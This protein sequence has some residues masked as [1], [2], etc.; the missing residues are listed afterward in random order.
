MSS[1]IFLESLHSFIQGQ[2]PGTGDV[3]DTRAKRLREI[4]QHATAHVPLYR[5]LY[6]A[7]KIDIDGIVT[8]NDLWRLPTVEKADYLRCGAEQYVDERLSKSLGDLHK[9]TTSGS[10]GSAL[11]LYSTQEE[12]DRQF[13]ALWAAW[14]S[15]G[16]T[17]DDRLFLM[18]A[19][20]LERE[21]P[22]FYGMFVPYSTPVDQAARLFEQ[23]QPT[24][25][26]G[27]VESIAMLAKE[28][29]ERDVR[30]RA[31]VRAI[32]HFGVTYSAQMRAMIGRAFDAWTVDLYGCFEAGWLGYECEQHNGFHIPE[33]RVIVQIAHTGKPNE[34]AAPG[35]IGEVIIT[36]LLRSTM[37]FIRYRLH[38]AAAI[39]PTPCPCG[40]TSARI[41]N[42]EGRWAEFLVGRDSRLFSPAAISVELFLDH[43]TVIDH[44]I[45]QDAR[46]HLRVSLVLAD[47]LSDAERVRITSIL[48]RILGDV[49]ID[50]E[51]V[52]EIPVMP[53]GKRMRVLRTFELSSV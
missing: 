14:I 1:T 42:L 37:P 38:D 52:P 19:W 45:V 28:L 17:P 21:L 18:S 6:R 50:I 48:R 11:T 10:L 2:Q 22:P 33:G 8:P 41:M 9:Q 20:H 30:A 51:R 25:I 35:E 36:S 16:V 4:V 53:S 24:V 23:F 32:F 5:D 7:H 39:D 27:V 46:D 47:E 13:A 3:S 29:V 12:V 40:R 31:N 26:I 49:K 44:R 43:P 15:R 34:P